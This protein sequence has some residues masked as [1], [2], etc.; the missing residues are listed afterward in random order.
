MRILGPAERLENQCIMKG[1]KG[2]SK[3][4]LVYSDIIFPP[5]QCLGS[6]NMYNLGCENPVTLEDKVWIS[7][8]SA[9]SNAMILVPS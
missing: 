8:G 7:L 5:L 9:F 6:P 1:Y 3:Q 4:K 2:R